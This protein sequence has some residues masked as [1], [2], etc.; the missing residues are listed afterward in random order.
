M[1]KVGETDHP[2][3]HP[4]DLGEGDRF[5]WSFYN[6]NAKSFIQEYGLMPMLIRELNLDPGSRSLL[7]LKLDMINQAFLRIQEKRFKEE[8]EEQKNG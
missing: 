5:A 2:I 3:D 7:L 6:D 8:L 1:S 4:P